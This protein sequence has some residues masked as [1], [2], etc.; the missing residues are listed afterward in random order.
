MRQPPPYGHHERPPTGVDP[1]DL[2]PGRRWY[3]VGGLVLFAGLTAALVGFVVTVFSTVGLSGFEARA[4]AGESVGFTVEEPGFQLGLYTNSGQERNPDACALVLPDGTESGFAR[5]GY[6][7]EAAT[8]GE[9]WTLVGT[10]EITAP[11]EYALV[12]D[13]AP[14]GADFTVADNGE[15]GAGVVKGVVG[16]LLWAF[17]PSLAGLAAGVTIIVVTAVRRHRSKQRLLTERHWQ[18][19]HGRGRAPR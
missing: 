9:N 1:R 16:A 10:S 15:G 13:G 4:A 6:S 12:C 19:A 18:A 7:H 8:G 2:R 17:V 5:P 11:G 3:V 14:V